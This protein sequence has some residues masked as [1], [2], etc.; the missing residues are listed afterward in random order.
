MDTSYFFNFDKTSAMYGIYLYFQRFESV[1]GYC[2]QWSRAKIVIV[3]RRVF[4]VRGDLS[5]PVELLM[6][7]QRFYTH[8][9]QEIYCPHH[10][11]GHV[12]NTTCTPLSRARSR[13][14]RTKNLERNRVFRWLQ[15]GWSDDDATDVRYGCG[16]V[17]SFDEKDPNHRVRIHI[18]GWLITR[19]RA[20]SNSCHSLSGN[21]EI[22]V[23]LQI[24]TGGD[25]FCIYAHFSEYLNNN[26]YIMYVV[27]SM[28]NEL[29]SAGSP[30]YRPIAIVHHRYSRFAIMDT[31]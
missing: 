22:N 24:N 5:P 18:D 20:K 17:A 1:G 8:R 23:S 10:L 2:G 13:C 28:W 19:F 6:V 3:C 16:H 30:S 21:V 14:R 26:I 12:F 15:H 29:A 7:F 11:P 27:C 4:R 31:L 9:G 25:P